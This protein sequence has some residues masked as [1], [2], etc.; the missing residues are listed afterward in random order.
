VMIFV[1]SRSMADRIASYLN[2]HTPEAL[3][4]Q[5]YARHYH[6][7]MSQQYLDETCEAF[8]RPDG[9]CRILVATSGAAT[10]VDTRDVHMVIQYGIC[11]NSADALQRGGRAGRDEEIDALFLSMIEPWVYDVVL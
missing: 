7:G 2:N 3:R 5:K 6:G 4:N 11:P 8:T 10:G 1:D 9:P